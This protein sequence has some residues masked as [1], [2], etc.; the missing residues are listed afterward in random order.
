M[1][2]SPG[3]TIVSDSNATTCS[4]SGAWSGT[5]PT[6]GSLNTGA[7]NTN[8]TYSLTCTGTGG[9]ATG[10]TSITVNPLEEGE[11]FVAKLLVQV[12]I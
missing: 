4:A 1:S 3:S 2:L 6:S 7:L 11:E 12:V 9:S 10:A 8:S 5:E